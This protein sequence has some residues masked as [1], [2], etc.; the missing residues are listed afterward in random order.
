MPKAL[1]LQV[2]LKEHEQLEMRQSGGAAR[3]RRKKPSCS[4]HEKQGETVDPK[5]LREPGDAGQVR[6]TKRTREPSRSSRDK[7]EQTFASRTRKRTLDSEG[8]VIDGPRASN[9][10]AEIRRLQSENSPSELIPK[11]CFARLVKD[12]LREVLQKEG[13]SI[14]YKLT[15]SAMLLLQ[16]ACEARLTERMAAMN[17]LARHA[18]RV[19]ILPTDAVMLEWLAQH[20]I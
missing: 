19:T 13:R 6:G 17:K 11:V 1:E 3:A 16:Q 2:M 14:D 4:F 20:W 10:E 15:S 18:R 12:S 9:I 7:Y 5:E 8:H